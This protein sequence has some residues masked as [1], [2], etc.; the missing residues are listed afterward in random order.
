MRQNVDVIVIGAGM[1]GLATAYQL[2]QRNPRLH[3]AVLEKEAGPA[4]HQSGHN[5]GVIH[6]G[7]Y[8]KPGSLK[9]NNCFHGKQ[10]LITFCREH[11]IP[12]QKLGK[13]IVATREQ[14]FPALEEIEKRGRANGVENLKLI[15]PEE[16]KEIEPHARGLKALWIP[17]SH[18][19]SYRTIAEKL[20]EIL[21]SKGAQIL[22]GEEVLKINGTIL[23]TKKNVYEAKSLVNCAGLFSDRIARMAL[24]KP[25]YQILPFRGEYYHL[26]ADLVK[27]LIY[28]VPNPK[29]PFLG[30]HLTRMIDGTIEAGPNAVLA[31]AREGYRKTDFSLRDTFDLISYSGFWRMGLR[32]GNIGLY[33]IYRSFR[34]KAFLRDLQRLVPSIRE[35][36]LEP[37]GSGVRAQLVTR[38]G[39]MVDDFVILR[40]KNRIHVLNAPSPAA[41]ASFSIGRQIVEHILSTL[42]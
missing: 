10:E 28:P 8:Y 7:V 18:V 24:D 42:L 21:R 41:T 16:L 27:G 3:V 40:E 11:G 19:V 25:A 9:A 34:K 4:C 5:S 33:E 17:D 14:E 29:F 2:L 37:G 32:Y 26:K 38:E 1:V 13:V 31:M 23:E 15:G 6:S 12:Y 36:D 39:K 20:C 35:N 22:F 30:V